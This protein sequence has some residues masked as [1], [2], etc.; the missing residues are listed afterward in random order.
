MLE[1]ILH[2]IGA[3]ISE[4]SIIIMFKSIIR[5]DINV[6][7]SL[8]LMLLIMPL[9]QVGLNIYHLQI[10]N[11]LLTIIFFAFICINT[12]K[13]SKKESILY[14]I[15]IWTIN[16]I[17]D[18][19]MMLLTNII[20]TNITHIK[21]EFI[22]RFVSSLLLSTIIIAISKS[23]NITS[24]IN[25]I[26]IIIKK[27]RINRIIVPILIISFFLT[28]LI[29]FLNIKDKVIIVSSILISVIFLS[30][31]INYIYQYFYIKEISKTNNILNKNNE[32]NKGIINEYRIIMHNIES[33]LRSV[34]SVANPQATLLIENM[35]KEYKKSK[36][37]EINITEIP[38]GID[39]LIIQKLAKYKKYKINHQIKNNL[40]GNLLKK[41]GPKNYNSFYESFDICLNNAIEAT[42]KSKEK[43]LLVNFT[44]ST[45][46][47]TINIINTFAGT[48]DIEKIGN[49]NYTTKKGGNGIGLFS[50][51]MKK[52]IRINT[53]IMGNI[54]SQKILLKKG[55]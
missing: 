7:L 23:D 14:L 31:V 47:I 1:V 4:C 48:I 6:K 16:V 30:L 54:F 17:L 26:Y 34:E 33:R 42:I 38:Q 39:G 46:D 40:K 35:I 10:I 43:I 41:L 24:K 25:R 18:I 28:E 21:E 8:I 3:V 49:I 55:Y 32:T 20:N 52:N 15:I 37:T 51:F 12:F 2:Y 44:E 11:P 36:Y 27:I 9:I 50:L 13:C 45:T 53:K 29:A 22:L 5:K 19:I